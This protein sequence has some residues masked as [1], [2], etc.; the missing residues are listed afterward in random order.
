MG[1]VGDGEIG[2]RAGFARGTS[3]DAGKRETRG[4]RAPTVKKRFQMEE[5]TGCG[6]PVERERAELVHDAV[7]VPRGEL[8]LYVGGPR[9]DRIR[10][11]LFLRHGAR[12]DRPSLPPAPCPLSAL[13]V[14]A[15]G[16][17]WKSGADRDR[18]HLKIA[19]YGICE[20]DQIEMKLAIEFRTIKQLKNDTFMVGNTCKK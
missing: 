16:D 9:G 15:F 13:P 6:L 3:G 11:L 8:A 4:G 14:A 20:R 2:G 5:R 1:G 10:V 12:R 19:S 7:H 17:I 18:D